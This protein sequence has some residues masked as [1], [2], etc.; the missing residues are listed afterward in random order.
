MRLALG[1]ILWLIV[2]GG[3]GRDFVSLARDLSPK[4]AGQV[5]SGVPAALKFTHINPNSGLSHAQ[6]WSILQDHQGFMWFGTEGGLDRYDGSK[7]KAYHHDD[8]DPG[9]LS[10]DYIWFLYE[11][12]EGTLWVG[13]NGGGLEQYDRDRD[14]F[15]HYRHDANDPNSLPQ[16]NIKSI[17]EDAEG[18]LWVGTNGGL[19]T[20]DRKTGKFRTYTNIF[21]ENGTPTDVY[22]IFED[23]TAGV[24]WLSSM[25]QG[26]SAFDPATGKHVQYDHSADNPRSLSSDETP[27]LWKDHSGRLWVGTYGGLDL[28]DPNSRSFTHFRHDPEKPE[29]L[30]DNHVQKILEDSSGQFWVATWNGLDLF[31]SKTGRFTHYRHN[32]AD[33]ESLGD[34]RIRT[35]FAGR[36]GAIWIGTEDA[37]VS[38]LAGER[39]KFVTYR[40]DPF[41][42]HTLTNSSVYA[43]H[44][45]RAGLL[46]IGTAEGLNRF[47][48]HSVTRYVYDP[49]NPNSLAANDIRA[50]A[51]DQDG[52]W[53]GTSGG[54]LDHF[55]G[56]RFTHYRHDAGKPQ[57]LARDF[58]VALYPEATGGLWIGVLGAGLD[59]FDGRSFTHYQ[60][61][62]SNPFSLPTHE[63]LS[64]TEDETG[65]LWLGTNNT[66]LIRFDRAGEFVSYPLDPNHR[67]S[68]VNRIDSIYSDHKGSLWVGAKTGLFRFDLKSRQ[69]THHYTEHDGL[70]DNSVACVLGDDSGNVWLSTESGGISRFATGRHTFRNY[71]RG[72]GLQSDQFMQR[73]CSQ[74]ANG[75]MYFGG[76]NGF[77]A[78]RA[79]Q[80][81]DNPHAPPVVLTNFELFNKPVEVGGKNSPLKKAISVADEITLNHDQSVFTIHFAALNYTAPSKNRYLYKMEGFDQDWRTT[82]ERM[83]FATYTNLDPGRYVFHVLGSNNDG[84][85]NKAGMSLRIHI[86]PPWWGTWWFRTLW[87]LAFGLLI[88]A[89]YQLRVRTMAE[90]ERRFRMLAENAP[91]VIARFDRD[92]LC[93]YVN[94][95]IEK[96]VG[97]PAETLIGKSNVELGMPVP[98]TVDAVVTKVLQSGRSEMREF[99]FQTVKGVRSFESRLVPEMSA[100]SLESILAITRDITERKRAELAQR[101]AE[102]KYRMLVEK[103]PAITYV[104][105]WGE[106]REW[107][108]VSP[109][110]QQLLGFSPAEWIESH[111][112]WLKQIHSDDRSRVLAAESHTCRPGDHYHVEYRLFTR[113]GRTL[114]VSDDAEAFKDPNTDRLM[115]RGILFDITERRRAEEEYR[116]FFESNLAGNFVA[117]PDGRL[118]ACNPAFARMFGFSSV[119]EAMQQNMATLYP[120]P[121][122]RAAF[123]SRLKRERQLENFELELRRSNGAPIYVVASVIGTVNEEGELLQILGHLI[124]ETERRKAEQQFLQSQKMEAVGRLAGGV[125]HD[126]NNLLGVILG[127]SEMLLE[128]LPASDSVHKQIERICQASK[129]AVSL[130]RRLLAFSRK[131]VLQP[132][133]INLN[134][135]VSE[136]G[137]ILP[138]LIEEDVRIVISLDPELGLVKAD[139]GQ[140]EQVI[141]NLAVNARDAMPHGGTLTLETANADLDSSYAGHQG[142]R[143]N[144]RHIMLKVSDTGIG[145]DELTLSRIFEPFFTTKEVGKGTGL[146]LATVYGIVQQSGG[147]IFVN[148]K[149]GRG[150]SFQIYLPQVQVTAEAPQTPE[151]PAR[152]AFGSETIL[153]VE[154]AP[155]LRE[156][157]RQFL[158]TYGYKVLE[159]PDAFQ[160]LEIAERHKQEVRLLITDVVMPGMGGRA[161]ADRLISIRPGIRVLYISGYT[162]DANIDQ[163]VLQSVVGFLPKPYTRDALAS[164]VREL[165]GTPEA[166]QPAQKTGKE[167]GS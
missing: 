76:S 95:A 62:K 98:K 131:Q 3:G 101:E 54:G 94:P 18:R 24:L 99:E 29:S 134:A 32:A 23:Q 102:A 40:H 132:T 67:D 139:P 10:Y 6:V 42:P 123:I 71:D 15:I 167:A 22:S 8:R 111:D 33:P 49:H 7:I 84:V 113:D 82:D 142:D 41:D 126:F 25:H 122:S 72:D 124:D 152:A 120:N 35:L 100:G 38:R 88:F 110:V 166:S 125:A 109:Q 17:Y 129:H 80:L 90:R 55:D 68:E 28:F 135:V 37:G 112:L 50:I 2:L 141:L 137:K 106:Q 61:Q 69:F 146:G 130:T 1:L 60:E 128:Q 51:E 103:V 91:D 153:L 138:R 86:T 119:E 151:P 162:D 145:M 121:E 78:F 136:L 127:Y 73:A 96:Y 47:D 149:P 81:K 20:L 163:G 13:T 34:N 144:S 53:I 36:T 116:R 56:R 12:H 85:W 140:I 104:A 43:L 48:G 155:P 154:D 75:E 133:V 92:L 27:T 115:L 93:R 148:S 79:D 52:L 97:V 31:D 14:T 5:A 77:N 66:G 161:L 11:D 58:I 150:T 45:D 16:D 87:G 105:Q 143:N 4:R 158:E 83:P 107:T 108:Y 164:K 74:G 114:W 147:Y 63:V 65:T 39:A 9:S 30:C 59:Y 64:M 46:W 157:T 118:L 44:V 57:S 21:A 89:G 159:A 156:L 117:T 19:S 26:V 165:L 160:A 70:P